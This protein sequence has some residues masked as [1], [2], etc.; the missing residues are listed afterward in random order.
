MLPI[1]RGVPTSLVLRDYHAGNLMFLKDRVGIKA[2]GLLDFQDAVVG[3]ITYDIVSL[4]EDARLDVAPHLSK[5]LI[6]RYLNAF[7][8]V[9][10]ESF[11]DSYDLLGTQRSMKII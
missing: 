9:D 5:L 10:R 11:S 2:C 7:P 8:M 1:A 6:T 3:P 4:L